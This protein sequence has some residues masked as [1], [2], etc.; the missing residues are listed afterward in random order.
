M[1]SREVPNGHRGEE[2]VQLYV[3]SF[4]ALEACG[5]SAPRPGRF[6]IGAGLNGFGKSRPHRLS[7]PGRFIKYY[8][9]NAG[10]TTIA[11]GHKHHIYVM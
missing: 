11:T 6:S 1:L 2:Q 10:H 9:Q 7:N 3:H 4:P 8:T 5:Y